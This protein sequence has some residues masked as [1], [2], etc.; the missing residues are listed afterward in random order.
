M[1]RLKRVEIGLWVRFSISSS[2]RAGIIPL[3]PPPSMDKTFIKITRPKII[4]LI[5]NI[6]HIILINPSF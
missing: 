5:L 2:I 6:F 4:N 3:M 1:I